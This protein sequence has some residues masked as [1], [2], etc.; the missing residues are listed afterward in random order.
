MPWLLDTN[1]LSENRRLNPEPKLLAIVADCPLDELYVSIVT[2]AELRFGIER[3]NAGGRRDELE[4][5]AHAHH[6]AQ[7]QSKGFAGD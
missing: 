1:I 5:V 3:L 7:V 2:V 6:T 4:P